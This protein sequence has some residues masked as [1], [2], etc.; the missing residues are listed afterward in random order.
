MGNRLGRGGGLD[1]PGDAPAAGTGRV[2]PAQR[3]RLRL[4]ARPD[5]RLRDPC[6]LGGADEAARRLPLPHRR[7]PDVFPF[8]IGGSASFTVATATTTQ[9]FRQR[10]GEQPAIVRALGS[11]LGC[12]SVC[13]AIASVWLVGWALGNWLAWLLGAFA[14]SCVYLVPSALELTVAQLLRPLLAV[15]DLAE[16]EEEEEE[17]R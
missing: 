3:A 6:L 7:R 1:Q 4:L 9:G 2:D 14:A 12:V 10:V 11:S 13:G 17:P 15:D 16:P 5:R 8:V